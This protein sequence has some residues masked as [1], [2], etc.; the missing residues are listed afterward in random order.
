V[1]WWWGAACLYHWIGSIGRRN[2]S[3]LFNLMT[4]KEGTETFEENLKTTRS[5]QNNRRLTNKLN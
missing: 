4:A 1:W 3:F 5:A 2:I